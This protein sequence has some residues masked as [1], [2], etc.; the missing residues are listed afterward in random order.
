M[1]AELGWTGQRQGQAMPLSL[2][3]ARGKEEKW[4]P[5]CRRHRLILSHDPHELLILSHDPHELLNL[6]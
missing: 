5:Q 1:T 2:W 3:R 4:S 6:R